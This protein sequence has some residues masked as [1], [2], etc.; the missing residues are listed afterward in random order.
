MSSPRR[1]IAPVFLLA[2]IAAILPAIAGVRNVPFTRADVLY[3]QAV[4][5][6][7]YPRRSR[8]RYRAGWHGEKRAQFIAASPL[9]A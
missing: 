6:A 2:C 8:L 4:R 7:V 5:H 9:A 1:R 3:S